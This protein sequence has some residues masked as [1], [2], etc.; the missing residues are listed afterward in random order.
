M[1]RRKA[2]KFRYCCQ[3]QVLYQINLTLLCSFRIW[4]LGAVLRLEMGLEDLS[5]FLVGFKPSLWFAVVIAKLSNWTETSLDPQLSFSSAPSRNL[6][7]AGIPWLL[8]CVMYV[9]LVQLS[10]EHSE[11]RVAIHLS[12]QLQPILV[13]VS[14]DLVCFLFEQILSYKQMGQSSVS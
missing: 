9:L 14:S 11:S 3:I 8:L 7:L 1:T 2:D 4:L 12:S 5:W 10:T 13:S 6:F